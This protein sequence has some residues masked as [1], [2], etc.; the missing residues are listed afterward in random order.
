MN[1][2]MSV[3]SDNNQFTD[4]VFDEEVM[5][6]LGPIAMIMGVII[7]EARLI[8]AREEFVA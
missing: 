7:E 3:R 1:E 4:S 6:M 5:E 2:E 8:K